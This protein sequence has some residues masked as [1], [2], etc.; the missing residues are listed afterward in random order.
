MAGRPDTVEFV[1]RINN[2]WKEKE[3]QDIQVFQNETWGW[4]ENDQRLKG[5]L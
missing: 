4:L 5:L 3:G 1:D 2:N